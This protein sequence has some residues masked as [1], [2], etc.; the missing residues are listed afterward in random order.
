MDTLLLVVIEY[1][2]ILY[3]C[4][5]IKT[6]INGDTLWTKTLT[7][8]YNFGYSVQQTNDNGYIIV[9]ETKDNYNYGCES[10]VYIVK[11]NENGDTLWTGLMVD[12]MKVISK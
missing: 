5:I 11:I 8:R 10:D 12:H 9:G 1:L 3:I 2:L 6:D 7:S 4:N